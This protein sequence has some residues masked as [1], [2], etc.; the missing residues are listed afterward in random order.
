MESIIGQAGR[1]F[2]A[3]VRDFCRDDRGVA[4]VEFALI[5]PMFL[6]LT[7]GTIDVA[8]LLYGRAALEAGAR[9]ASRKGLT[10]STPNPAINRTN[11]ASLTD[12]T[13]EVKR[14]AR[15][16]FDITDSS[17]FKIYS[18]VIPNYTAIPEICRRFEANGTTCLPANFNDE[19]G[20]GAYDG[21]AADST[22]C[23]GQ[24]V[25]YEISYDWTPYTPLVSYVMNGGQPIRLQAVAVVRNEP[26]VAAGSC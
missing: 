13:N 17:R 6:L 21:A 23:T 10:G 25:Y 20:N 1:R 24:I 19:N 12:I 14:Y 4:A 2:A 15:G 5:L 7:V 18:R 22:G 26:W 9:A 16:F 11:G 3:T 8:A